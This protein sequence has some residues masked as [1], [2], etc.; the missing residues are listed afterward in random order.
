MKMGE[1]ER[2]IKFHKLQLLRYLVLYEQP[3]HCEHTSFYVRY[4]PEISSCIA[5][6]ENERVGMSLIKF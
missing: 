4:N 5:L 2:N 3:V 6:S 1:R